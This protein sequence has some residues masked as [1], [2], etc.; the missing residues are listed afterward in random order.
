[1]TLSSS[2]PPFTTSRGP[3]RWRCAFAGGLLAAASTLP[4]TPDG[5]SPVR[6]CLDSASAGLFQG[7]WALSSMGLPFLF[8][9]VV[10]ATCIVNA[11]EHHPWT[12]RVL[13]LMLFM[14][15]GHLVLFAVAWLH[16]PTFIAI[17]PLMGFAVCSM[18]A[19]GWHS[20]RTRMTLHEHPSE[21]RHW[22][23]RWGAAMLVPLAA[24]ARLQVLGDLP[25]GICVDV[26]LLS[27]LALVFATRVQP[28]VTAPTS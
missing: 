18:V 25:L 8:G 6:W 4:L 5:D 7:L 27:C 2:T 21:H 11:W 13:R 16:T 20:E 23:T 14:L 10:M 19:F 15:H 12:V 1:M 17:W 22:L 28:Q 26:S 24:W 3:S 9:A